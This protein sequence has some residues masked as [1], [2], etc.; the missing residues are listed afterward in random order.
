[1][2]PI[3]ATGWKWPSSSYRSRSGIRLSSTPAMASARAGW[4]GSSSWRAGDLGESLRWVRIGWRSIGVDWSS[5]CSSARPNPSVRL[6]EGIR[7]VEAALSELESLL[8]G[9]NY[10]VA[11]DLHRVPT[12][13]SGTPE[14]HV[15]AALGGAGALITAGMWIILPC[16]TVLVAALRGIDMLRVPP[17]MDETRLGGA[18][19]FENH[20]AHWRGNDGAYRQGIRPP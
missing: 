18:F 11:L 3:R 16:T 6:Q 2:P 8:P 12:I 4:R 13:P 14:Q 10:V 1:M 19:W 7:Q 15:V 5:A 20:R 17:E 9:L